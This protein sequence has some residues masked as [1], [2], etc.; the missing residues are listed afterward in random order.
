MPASDEWFDEHFAA[1]RVMV[2]LRGL[3]ADTSVEYAERAWEAGV[4]MLEVPIQSGRDLEALTAVSRAAARRGLPVGAGTVVDPAQVAIAA[5]AGAGY[6]VSPG[7]DTAVIRVSLDAGLP[8]LPGV[9][10]ASDIQ[11]CRRLGLGWL[12][13]FPASVLTADW[14]SAMQGPFPEV[15]F[16]ATGGVSSRNAGDFLRAGSRAVSISLSPSRPDQWD[17]LASLATSG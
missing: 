2:I 1:T 6:T 7:T 17:A 9:G 12:K 15:S 14:I 16:V 3:G 11:V 8:T 5:A 10:T 13:A 4:T